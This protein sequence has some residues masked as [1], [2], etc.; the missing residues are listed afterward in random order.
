MREVEAQAIGAN[1]RTLLPDMRSEH[2][3]QCG[4]QKMRRG[5]VGAR[6]ATALGIDAQLDR[7]PTRKSPCVISTT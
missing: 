3:L 1:H 6:G 7:S 4:V 2:V 5:M